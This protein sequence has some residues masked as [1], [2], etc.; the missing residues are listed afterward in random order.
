MADQ[1]GQTPSSRGKI[2]MTISEI[3]AERRWF[4]MMRLAFSGVCLAWLL[5]VL[6]AVPGG[7][8]ADMVTDFSASAVLGVL[9]A[10]A[11]FGGTVCFMVLWRPSFKG[12]SPHD[13]IHVLFGGG[14]LVRRRAQFKARLAAE[15]RRARR[16][17]A[18]PFSSIVLKLDQQA[19]DREDPSTR[20]FGG[21]VP[22]L[23]ARSVARADDIVGVAASDE[24]WILAPG[25]NAQGRG[26][27]TG[28]LAQ[29]LAS[30]E[31]LPH[32]DGV[33]MA[34]VTFGEDGER[35]DTL[36]LAATE[37]LAAP[38]ELLNQAA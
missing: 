27:M 2:A 11:A 17:K 6:W 8:F 22:V 38:G 1:S 35:A 24:I 15:C 9:F 12:E 36:L 30:D 23:W 19:A 37:K 29:E 16:G 18:A 14:L 32:F 25:A 31:K 33:E 10:L 34:A 20:R 5:L 3:A 4:K 28:R 21:Q 26:I 13:F 7:P